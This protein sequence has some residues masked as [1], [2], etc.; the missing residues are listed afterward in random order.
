MLS[1]NINI[2]HFEVGNI[3]NSMTIVN[4]IVLARVFADSALFHVLLGNIVDVSLFVYILNI[5]TCYVPF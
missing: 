4:H 3:S 2:N 1:H 5:L